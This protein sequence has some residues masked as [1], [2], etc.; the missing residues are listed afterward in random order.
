MKTKIFFTVTMIAF[1]S[2]NGCKDSTT[3]NTIRGSIGFQS[4][5]SP[6]GLNGTVI[7]AFNNPIA[8][9]DIHFL[10]TMAQIGLPKT[11]SPQQAMPSTLIRFSVPQKGHTSVRIYRLG[12]REFISTLVDTV[13]QAGSYSITFD[14]GSVT[15]GIYVYQLISGE[16]FE[17]KLMTLLNDNLEVLLKTKPLT[18]TD[19]QGKFRLPQSIFALDEEF[20]LTNEK[21]PDAIGKAKIDSIRI[22]IY[23]SDKSPFIEWMKIN[24]YSNMEKTFIL[25]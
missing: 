25:K 15:N 6:F 4:E 8:G 5:R 24:K 11:Q 1:F 14:A 23:R 9:A 10:F 3:G 13:L 7:D 20:I 17:E 22:V 12:T 21:S 16:Y 18:K 19:F 2:F